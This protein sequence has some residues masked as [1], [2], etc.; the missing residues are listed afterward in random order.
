MF[1]SFEADT[2]DVSLF[3]LARVKFDKELLFTLWFVDV[4]MVATPPTATI[5]DTSRMSEKSGV[6]LGKNQLLLVPAQ[7][8]SQ[9]I[10]GGVL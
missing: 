9:R 1:P 7:I 8:A 2:M 5:V 4:V 3:T 6:Y 10:L